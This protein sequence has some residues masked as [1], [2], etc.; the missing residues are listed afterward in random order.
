MDMIRKIKNLYKKLDLKF[1][2]VQRM[3]WMDWTLKFINICF[4]VEAT[5]TSLFKVITIGHPIKST[6]LSSRQETEKI[7]KL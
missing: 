3:K 1:N 7:K 2:I 4:Y 5:R 6:D